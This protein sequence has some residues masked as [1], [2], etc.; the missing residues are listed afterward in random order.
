MGGGDKPHLVFMQ[1]QGSLKQPQQ[2][3][4]GEQLG[5]QQ[6]F[7]GGQGEHE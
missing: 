4:F 3:G 1:Q 5:V 7:V 6:F 2:E